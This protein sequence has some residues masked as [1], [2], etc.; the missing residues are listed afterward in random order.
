MQEVENT[1]R[2]TNLLVPVGSLG[3]GVRASEVRVGLDNGADV[4]AT[5]AGST[6]SGAAYLAMGVSKNNRAA[7]KR[8]LLVLMA[9]QAKRTFRCWLVHAAS[10]AEI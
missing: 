5:D 10:L 7:V 1:I 3:A 6:D 8:D 4:I 9:A 2:V